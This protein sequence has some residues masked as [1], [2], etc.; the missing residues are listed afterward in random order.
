MRDRKLYVD[1]QRFIVELEQ[2]GYEN[3]KSDDFSGPDLKSDEIKKL[4]EEVKLIASEIIESRIQEEMKSSEIN[5][6]ESRPKIESE[7][8]NLK[9]NEINSKP[10]DTNQISGDIIKAKDEVI[11]IL[12]ENIQSKEKDIEQLRSVVDSMTKQNEV[13]TRQ[14]AWLTNLITAPQRPRDNVKSNDFTRES[15]EEDPMASDDIR[16]E[17]EGDGSEKATT[18]AGEDQRHPSDSL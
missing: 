9:S 17:M 14:N 10:N 6:S 16:E 18:G 4:A 13:I 11:E 1:V 8:V 2:L 7:T 12:K 5:S 3:L 15:V